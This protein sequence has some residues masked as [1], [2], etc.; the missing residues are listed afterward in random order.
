M[1]TPEPRAGRPIARVPSL[2]EVVR[3]TPSELL[4]RGVRRLAP[5]TAR[6]LRAEQPGARRSPGPQENAAPSIFEK[7]GVNSRA[8]LAATIARRYAE[9]PRPAEIPD[10]LQVRGGV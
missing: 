1:N 5:E 9:P 10:A 3:G 2:I 4:R 8:Q 7:L 6:D